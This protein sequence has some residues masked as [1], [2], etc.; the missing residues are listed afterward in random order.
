MVSALDLD[1]TLDGSMH[2]SERAR[3]RTVE[4]FAQRLTTTASERNVDRP[5]GLTYRDAMFRQARRF[6]QWL[7][8]IRPTYEPFRWK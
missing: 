3:S 8:G 2:L 7:D 1:P 5:G 6:R 4:R